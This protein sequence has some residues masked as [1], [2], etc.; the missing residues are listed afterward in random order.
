M[1]H[2]SLRYYYI[3][4]SLTLADRNTIGQYLGTKYNITTS[5]GSSN[6]APEFGNMLFISSATQQQTI[7]LV[8]AGSQALNVSA[9]TI[10]D[11]V[12]N[13][14]Q[15][16]TPPGTPFVIAAG[17]TQTL[18]IEYD[19]T[20]AEIST[21]TLQITSDTGGVPGTI[22]TV[23]LEGRRFG[24]FVSAASGDWTTVTNWTPNGLP[25]TED[26]V[27]I[28]ASDIIDRTSNLDVD[29]DFGGSRDDAISTLTISGG[30]FRTANNLHVGDGV[31]EISAGTLQIQQGG[32]LFV[33]DGPSNNGTVNQTGGSVIIENNNLLLGSNPGF[34]SP[35]SGIYNMDGGLLSITNNSPGDII[36]GAGLG[37]DT[38]DKTGVF[39]MR[40][41]T[42]QTVSDIY[43]GQGENADGTLNVEGGTISAD[44]N[45][46]LARGIDRTG[47]INLTGGTLAGTNLLGNDNGVFAFNWT[48][49]T[50]AIN[51]DVQLSTSG[52][53]NN[54]GALN[55]G[56]L[57]SI[58]V[59]NFIPGSDVTD[60]TQ[61]ATGVYQVD[62]NGSLSDLATITSGTASLNGTIDVN[63]IGFAPFGVTAWEVFR[64]EDS[65]ASIVDNGVTL[66][67]PSLANGI[68]SLNVT[69]DSVTITLDNKAAPVLTAAGGGS[70]TVLNDALSNNVVLG[71]VRDDDDDVSGL[72][73]VVDDGS[74]TI[75]NVQVSAEGIITGTIDTTG[76]TTGTNTTVMITATDGDT[77]SDN[78]SI[79]LTTGGTLNFAPFF[80]G[81]TSAPLAAGTTG[82]FLNVAFVNDDAA[83]TGVTVSVINAGNL[84]FGSS[85]SITSFNTADGSI[86]VEIFIPTGSSEGNYTLE[87][88]ANDGGLSGITSIPVNI[89]VPDPTAVQKS[90]DT[91]Q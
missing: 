8:N 2:V 18:T 83:L 13:S 70:L 64:T 65:S 73:I 87:I 45:I 90:W 88:E 29:P 5:Y 48:S 15:L 67:A 6:L 36:I 17:S 72:N 4:G 76:L 40:G 89:I 7:D 79:S 62:L 14:F 32:Q 66:N 43:V 37:E 20:N 10:A 47:T 85:A 54:G 49:G 26:T 16:I 42:V 77:L 44:G 28:I 39:N 24:A 22:T 52:L 56:G 12:T 78:I 19:S 30:T 34:G 71:V 50:L 41:G 51:G 1:I 61:N 55:P 53:V 81:V 57:G 11:D 68:F 31:I 84:P 38:V 69:A 80:T 74:T 46:E 25:Q 35:S 75:T 86:D 82:T 60:Y 27:E 33:G 59:T 91:Y 63:I 9:L 23:D 58:G 3:P 21:A